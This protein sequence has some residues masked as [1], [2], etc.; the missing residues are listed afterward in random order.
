MEYTKVMGSNHNAKKVICLTTGE[1]FSCAK[2]E[3]IIKNISY[4]SILACCKST[5]SSTERL[6]KDK[7]KWSFYNIS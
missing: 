5:P 2:E 1:I 4:G 6:S 7:L 3:S